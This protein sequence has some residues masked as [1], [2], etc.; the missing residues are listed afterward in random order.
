[1]EWGGRALV[2]GVK[3]VYMFLDDL[4][5]GSDAPIQMEELPTGVVTYLTKCYTPFCVDEKPCYVYSCPRRVSTLLYPADLLYFLR[6]VLLG[7][8]DNLPRYC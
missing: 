8:R 7:N 4:E 5:G 6:E 2:D 1:M 3:D